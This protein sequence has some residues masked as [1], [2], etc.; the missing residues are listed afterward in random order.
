M[1]PDQAS[2]QSAYGD[3]VQKLYASLFDAYV[4]AG[5]DVTQEQ[6]A[7]ECFTKGLGSARRSRDRAP[8]LLAR[9]RNLDLRRVLSVGN[10]AFSPDGKTLASASRDT[11]VRLWDLN[12]NSWV[13][14][15]AIRRIVEGRAEDLQATENLQPALSVVNAACLEALR[16]RRR[17]LRFSDRCGVP[18]PETGLCGSR[19]RQP[20]G[21]VGR[22][23]DFGRTNSRDR[24]KKRPPRACSASLTA[25][26]KTWIERKID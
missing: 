1:N 2:I 21:H 5:G 16:V 7:D 3:A 25:M 20:G 19:I 23:P 4:T 10:L 11:T 9:V 22:S 12:P 14:S 15:P 13:R 18:K 26:P 24:G 6:Q 17:C 8:A